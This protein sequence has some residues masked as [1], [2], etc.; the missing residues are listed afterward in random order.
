MT[1]STKELEEFRRQ[2]AAWFEQNRPR[3]PGFLL[4]ESFMEVGSD[5]QFHYLRDWQ[6]QV[7]AAG[8]LGLAW[9][10]AYGGGGQP[11]AYQDVAT[12]E[13]TRLNVPF[14]MN[15]IGLN[16]AGPLIL[17][18]GT[19]GLRQDEQRH[20][21]GV[22]HCAAASSRPSNNSTCSLMDCSLARFTPVARLVMGATSRL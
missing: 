21:T 14:M 2:A 17:N 6:A 15:T 18:M 20:Q 22:S 11:Q 1:V 5:D 16:W 12:Q 3:D 19:E 13:M 8:Y 10:A 7:Y 9:P 4:P